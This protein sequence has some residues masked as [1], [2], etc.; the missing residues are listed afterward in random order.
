MRV[1]REGS[2]MKHSRLQ[3]QGQ[4]LWFYRRTVPIETDSLAVMCGTKSQN[5]YHSLA[6][7]GW[8]KEMAG[9]L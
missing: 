9:A 1:A 3:V 2:E 5:P 7:W 8:W 4:E 6:L